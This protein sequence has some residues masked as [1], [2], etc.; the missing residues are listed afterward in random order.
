M[1]AL[2]SQSLLLCG[3]AS[4]ALH[5]AVYYTQRAI[6]HGPDADASLPFAVILLGY[7]V[8]TCGLF[9]LYAAVLWAA[10]HGRI[11][12]RGKRRLAILIPVVFT[13]ALV[14]ALPSLSID[15]YSY[16]ARGY[17]Q[18][19]L[20]QNPY[21]VGARAVGPTP[22]GRELAQYGWQ[23]IHPVSPYGPVVTYL[24]RAVVAAVR[25]VRL[26]ILLLKAVAAT[27]FLASAGVIWIMLGRVKPDRQLLGTL[28]FLWN[29]M[30]IWELA[31]EGHNDALM[32][33]F[34]LLA[35]ALIVQQR[36]ISGMTMMALAV[37]TKYLPLMLVP[38]CAVY[39]WRTTRVRLRLLAPAV[40]GGLLAATVTVVLF[41]PL[42]AGIDTFRGVRL[43]GAPGSTGSTPTVV[44][45]ALQRVA[46]HAD[47]DR[48][49]WG[50]VVVALLICV[51]L[52]ARQVTDEPG[53]L[54]AAAVVWLL[55]LLL[56]CPTYWP[57]YATTVVALMALVPERPF[58]A[59]ALAV[60]LAA[61]LAAPLT[62]V[63]VHGLISRPLFLGSVWII[64]S[65][66]PLLVLAM[67]RPMVARVR[68]FSAGGAREPNA[69]DFFG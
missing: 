40:L 37:L 61:R 8:A 21:L 59:I 24:D 69:S 44:L 35:L 26:Q 48:I 33:L 29:P 49:V 63:F 55:F 27:A 34:V 1:R 58:V 66:V 62:M 52:Q 64:G 45:E 7:A 2:L 14:P 57:W 20:G 23:P 28:A 51:L 15:I 6:H 13:I 38:L 53:L 47:W 4:G 12:T 50:L 60:S 5:G 65:L 36:H 54:R 19:E 31:G 56:F 43:N 68:L 10:W 22:F 3:A 16:L 32:I 41:L 42:W 30:V 18:A 25:N 11:E 9:A 17:L 67:Q 46:P 39:V